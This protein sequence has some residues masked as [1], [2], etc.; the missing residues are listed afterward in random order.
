MKTKKP[1]KYDTNQLIKISQVRNNCKIVSILTMLSFIGVGAYIAFLARTM[2]DYE[3]CY[4]CYGTLIGVYLSFFVK[5]IS[6]F[7]YVILGDW[8]INPR[9]YR[10]KDFIMGIAVSVRVILSSL[11]A[12]LEQWKYRC[13]NFSPF[14]LREITVTVMLLLTLYTWLCMTEEDFIMIYGHKCRLQ[15]LIF[16]IAHNFIFG[17]FIIEFLLWSN[18]ISEKIQKDIMSLKSIICG[19]S[20]ICPQRLAEN[21]TSLNKVI[22]LESKAF[23]D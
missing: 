21:S 6:F 5:M 4:D 23:L 18:L 16:P 17:T 1:V 22:K 8:H 14:G 3:M 2:T 11:F 10:C 12:I 20:S 13:K 7:R 9:E 15:K 19:N